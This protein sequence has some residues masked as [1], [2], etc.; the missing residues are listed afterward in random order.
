MPAISSVSSLASTSGSALID[1]AVR[2]I[3][4]TGPSGVGKSWIASEIIRL[5]AE[6]KSSQAPRLQLM[7]SYTTRAPRDEDERNGRTNYV[8]V[9]E[10]QYQHMKSRGLFLWHMGFVGARYATTKQDVDDALRGSCPTLLDLEP[11]S[12]EKLRLHA[13]SELLCSFY[14]DASLRT[15]RERI[16]R[17][18]PEISD[19]RVHER[20]EDCL[21]YPSWA[22]GS[23]GLHIINNDTDN[24]DTAIA[25]VLSHLRPKMR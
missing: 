5:H 7:P 12:L 16:K 15:L 4:L 8:F 21:F 11:N 6:T 2:I 13:P 19:D 20:V 3:T 22:K 17:R 24:R 25:N 1:P 10:D 14:I 9:T 18:T 23:L